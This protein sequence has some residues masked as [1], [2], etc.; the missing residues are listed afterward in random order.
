MM[1]FLSAALCMCGYHRLFFFTVRK[2]FRVHISGGKQ[3]M[4]QILSVQKGYH[5]SVGPRFL[6]R[7]LSRGICIERIYIIG[8]KARDWKLVPEIPDIKLFIH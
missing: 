6:A 5:R 1:G 4:S 8:D 2:R 7:G 3:A